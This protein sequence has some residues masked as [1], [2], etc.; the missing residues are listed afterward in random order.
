M[1]S[2]PAKELL[3]VAT[4]FVLTLAAIGLVALG[5]AWLGKQ[6]GVL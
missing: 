4:A 5:L 1:L 3:V 6:M 2:R